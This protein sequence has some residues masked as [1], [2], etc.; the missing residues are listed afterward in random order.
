ME[1]TQV[2]AETMVA[3]EIN[4]ETIYTWAKLETCVDMR[5]A[6]WVTRRQFCV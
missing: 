1:G 4:Q 5:G 3:V 6:G 2:E